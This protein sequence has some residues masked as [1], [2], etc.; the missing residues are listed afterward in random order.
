MV[1]NDYESY[2]WAQ[3]NTL[4]VHVFVFEFIMQLQNGLFQQLEAPHPIKKTSKVSIS[5]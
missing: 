3:Q 4:H 2:I 1:T 5:S